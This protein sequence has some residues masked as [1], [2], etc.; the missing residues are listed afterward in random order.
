MKGSL[1]QYYGCK[2]P[3]EE[4]RVQDPARTDNVTPPS[5]SGGGN[6]ELSDARQVQE[7]GRRR[8]PA[9]RL[10]AGIYSPVAEAGSLLS[11]CAE[12]INTFAGKVPP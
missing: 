1:P 4:G 12:S 11:G 2:M 7:R 6:P 9:G 3:E 5:E 10:G 8:S